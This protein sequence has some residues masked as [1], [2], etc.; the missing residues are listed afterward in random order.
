V[1]YNALWPWTLAFTHVV[2][3]GGD[4]LMLR[5]PG[6]SVKELIRQR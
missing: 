5:H 3:L 2:A 1:C 4:G 6:R